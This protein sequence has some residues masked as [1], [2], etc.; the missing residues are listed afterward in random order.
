MISEVGARGRWKLEYCAADHGLMVPDS[1]G[2]LHAKFISSHSS[3]ITY[4]EESF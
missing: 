3:E 1:L 2:S 4:S